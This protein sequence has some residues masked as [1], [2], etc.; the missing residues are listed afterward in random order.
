MG[1]TRKIMLSV[2]VAS[3]IG[4]GASYVRGRQYSEDLSVK[5]PELER[6]LEIRDL[7]PEIEKKQITYRT[8][9]SNSESLSKEFFDAKGTLR[10]L[11]E[12]RLNLEYEHDFLVSQK[13][14][15]EELSERIRISNYSQ[16]CYFGLISFGALAAFLGIHSIGSSLRERKR[17]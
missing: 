14:V 15:Q 9:V 3:A 10:M 11:D 6:I 5:S 12:K 16:I 2:A 13:P 1:L 8:A 4:A 7:L 17:N